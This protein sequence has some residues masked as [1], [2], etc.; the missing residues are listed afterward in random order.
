MGGTPKKSDD[1]AALRERIKKQRHLNKW[2]EYK[3]QSEPLLDEVKLEFDNKFKEWDLLL[4]HLNVRDYEGRFYLQ[5]KKNYKEI[6]TVTRGGLYNE[7]MFGETDILVKKED[8][9]EKIV[10]FTN[11]SVSKIR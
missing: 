10:K 4:D 1:V 8:E 2:A 3:L 9:V 6:E 5:H 11:K 7:K